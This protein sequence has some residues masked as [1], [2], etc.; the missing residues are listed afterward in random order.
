M[1]HRVY[2]QAVGVMFDMIEDELNAMREDRYKKL[3]LEVRSKKQC[4]DGD[5][6]FY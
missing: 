2:G 5:A 3:L 4:K 6:R 1:T